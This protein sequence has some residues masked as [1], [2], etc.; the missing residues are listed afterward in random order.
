[1][2]AAVGDGTTVVFGTTAYAPN[3]VSVQG[4]G[5]SRASVDSTHLGT[6]AGYKT[7]I[8]SNFADPGEVTLEIQHDPAL[9]VPV[10]GVFE[11]ITVDWGGN[12]DNYS[13]S[14]AVSGYD[15]GAN[16]DEMMTATVTLM[17]SGAITGI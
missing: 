2:A 11:I 17:V 12:G 3:I 10:L 15:P 13:Y 8:A 16:I 5:V 4:P 7:K 1:M 6:P 9:T 14:A